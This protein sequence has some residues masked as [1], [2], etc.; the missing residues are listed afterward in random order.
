MPLPT[1]KHPVFKINV[2]STGAQISYR[3]YTVQEEKLL[4][5]MKLSNDVDEIIG[6]IK[7]IINNCVFEDIDIEKFAMFDIEYL[8]LNIR[9]VSV[10]NI[11]ELNYSEEI[12]GKLVRVPFSVDIEQVKVKFNPEHSNTIKINEDMGIKMNYPNVGHML[13]LEDMILTEEFNSF[14]TDEYIYDIFLECVDSIYDADKVYSRSEFTKDELN[15]FI[16][17]LPADTMNHIRNFFDT[18]PSLE[19]EVIVAMP[20]GVNKTVMMKGLKD[21]FIF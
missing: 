9:K 2:P 20:S 5:I 11:I 12:D 15:Q 19:H 7:Q 3:P 13:K 18:L 4:L 16:S 21:F 14:K 1:I 8:F 6:T 17:S 10:S